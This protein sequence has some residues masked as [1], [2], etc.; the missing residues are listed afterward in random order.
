MFFSTS[1][2]KYEDYI[3]NIIYISTLTHINTRYFLFCIDYTYIQ[4]QKRVYTRA[5]D[6]KKS[7][8]L[9]GT[10]LTHIT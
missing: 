1:I 9:I 8:F 6:F 4:I 3:Y 5:T 7:N 2:D 10:S